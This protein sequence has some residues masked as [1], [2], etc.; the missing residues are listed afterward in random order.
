[1]HIISFVFQ[2]YARTLVTVSAT[3]RSLYQHKHQIAAQFAPVVQLALPCLGLLRPLF[4]VSAYL[5][6]Q[7]ITSTVARKEVPGVQYTH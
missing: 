3:D 5:F 4:V 1:M 7:H 6:V 2:L